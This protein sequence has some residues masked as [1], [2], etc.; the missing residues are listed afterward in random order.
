MTISMNVA[1]CNGLGMTA[2]GECVDRAA[3]LGLAIE[4]VV[5]PVRLGRGNKEQIRGGDQQ[6]RLEGDFNVDS[7]H[8]KNGRIKTPGLSIQDSRKRPF[9]TYNPGSGA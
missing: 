9:I 1:G 4:A 7:P 5:N 3:R 6:R 8:A 2:F